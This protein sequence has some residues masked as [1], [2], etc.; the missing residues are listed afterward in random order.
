M[1]VENACTYISIHETSPY[2]RCRVSTF[3]T[4]K[5]RSRF[6]SIY[7]DHSR[8]YNSMRSEVMIVVLKYPEGTQEN[9]VVECKHKILLQH[10]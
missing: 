3:T 8:T 7:Y 6:I 2:K 5:V 4:I 9:S 1:A 10:K